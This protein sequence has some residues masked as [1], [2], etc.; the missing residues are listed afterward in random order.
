MPNFC[1]N[2]AAPLDADARFCPS[3]RASVGVA[4][5]LASELTGSLRAGVRSVVSEAGQSVPPFVWAAALQ[6]F[7]LL[8][9][10]ATMLGGVIVT[11]GGIG[12]L[13]A[14]GALSSGLVSG[15][16]NMERMVLLGVVGLFAGAVDTCLSTVLVYGFLTI[17]HWAHG[18]FMVWLPVKVTLAVASYLVTPTSEASGATKPFVV[19]FVVG[20]LLILS[21]GALVVEFILVKRGKAALDL[22]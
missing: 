11:F 7:W 8:T 17:R 12:V 5:A 4:S 3:C 6:I 21:V 2:C 18:V 9:G 13:G 22:A 14:A 16:A 10:A 20:L 1:P 15:G 19:V